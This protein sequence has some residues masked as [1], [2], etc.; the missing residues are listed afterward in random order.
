MHNKVSIIIPAFNKY[1]LTRITINSILNQTYKNIEIILVDDGSTDFTYKLKEE[2]NDSIKYIYTKNNGASAARNIGILESKGDYLAF[3]DC[4]DI[5]E[6]E[7]IEKSIEVLKN[8]SSFDFIYSNVFFIDK[9]GNKINHDSYTQNHPGS[10]SIGKR[11]LLSDFTITNSTL[12]LKKSCLN[13]VSGFDENIFIAADRDFILR[14]AL[15]FKAF[16]IP[17]KLTGYRIGSG[18]TDKNLDVM[19]K[20]FLYLIDKNIHHIT[21]KSKNFK[22]RCYSN[23]YYNFAKKYASSNNMMLA[24]KY[25]IK[26][27]NLYFFNRYTL[28]ILV[29]ILL[30]YFMPNILQSYFKKIINY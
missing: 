30:I 17:Q 19:L 13:S 15:K 9:K 18:N 29:A 2:F 22:N 27:L 20:E 25:F 28:K 6:P 23:V 10:G 8:N 1:E 12:V 26:S 11:I 3:I 16:Y 7:K 4:D 5:Y 14:L 24:K 21:D